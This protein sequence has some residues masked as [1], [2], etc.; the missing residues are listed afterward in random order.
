[1]KQMSSLIRYIL[2][3]YNFQSMENPGVLERMKEGNSE[4]W[5]MDR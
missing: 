1:M 5:E 4:E 2:A 3:F